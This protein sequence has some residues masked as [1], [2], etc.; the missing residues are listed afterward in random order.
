MSPIEFKGEEFAFIDWIRRQ[1][2]EAAG[3]LIVGPGDDACV[4]DPGP[5]ARVA[6]TTDM[7]LE[8][9]HFTLSEVTPAELGHKAIGVSLSDVAAM[10]MTPIAC[11]VA[12]GLPDATDR[13]FTEAMYHGMRE[14]ADRFDVS[15]AGGDV[16][17]WR[18]SQVVVCVTALGRS[19]STAPVLR[20]GARA[21]DVI[22]VTGALG[23]SSLGRHVRFIP[24]VDESLAI[25]RDFSPHAMI[26]ISDGLSSDLA[27]VLVESEVG[28]VIDAQQVP[29]SG[30]AV[31]ASRADGRS[32][33]THAL[34]DGED[35]ELLV[36]LD[37]ADAERLVADAPF[38]TKVTI[39]GRII[40]GDEMRLREVD[41]G[42]RVIQPGGYEHLRGD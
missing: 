31:A 34:D 26:D 9:T 6:L 12:V 27:H 8:G 32:P 42:E 22:V 17:S 1:T 14:I 33:L 30:D 13:A 21:D 19:T 7:L 40:E 24:R 23:G 5:D 38:E 41:G 10:G 15:I 4:I 39:V 18:A 3:R 20:S 29:V 37:A 2:A 11:V 28:A 25:C 35:F 16:T 36:T